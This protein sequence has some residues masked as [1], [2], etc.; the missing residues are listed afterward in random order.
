MG[1]QLQKKKN[2]SSVPKV[3]RRRNPRVH[4][5]KS[6]GHP[7]IAQNW[8]KTQTLTQNY[9]R[10]GL[11]SK[12]NASTWCPPVTAAVAAPEAAP[13]A[14]QPGEARIIRDAEGNVIRIEHAPTHDEAL[15][16]PESAPVRA[17]TDV[18]RQLEA[19]AVFDADR[20]KEVRMGAGEEDWVA[21][22]IEKYGSDY[23]SMARDRKLNAWQH[24][25][26]EMRRK[27]MNWE[28]KQKQAKKAAAA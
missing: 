15:D 3:T 18:V 22:L 10:L 24:T 13:N 9:Q 11:S 20:V 1:R 16:A 8:D 21:R 28:K 25:A 17:K 6:F 4:K 12:L 23:A 26:G 19:E 2:K 5:I 27:C 7:L 14:L